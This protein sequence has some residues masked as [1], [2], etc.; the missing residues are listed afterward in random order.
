MSQK[1]RVAALNRAIDAIGPAGAADA[2]RKGATL[3]YVQTLEEV[4]N[5]LQ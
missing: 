5:W 2:E 3:G 4:Q 1:Q